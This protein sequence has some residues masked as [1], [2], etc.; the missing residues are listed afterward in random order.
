MKRRLTIISLRSGGFVPQQMSNPEHRHG[1]QGHRGHPQQPKTE[2][3]LPENQ[4][5]QK[6]QCR[7]LH[8]KSDRIANGTGPHKLKR[9]ED[10]VKQAR[11]GWKRDL[12]GSSPLPVKIGPAE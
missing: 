9:P 7:E 6:N 3:Q 4:E 8:Q 1:G 12:P 11:L 10:D 2:V 5:R